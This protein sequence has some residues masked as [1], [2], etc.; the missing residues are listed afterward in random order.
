[1]SEPSLAGLLQEHPYLSL[2]ANNRIRCSLTNHEM[3]PRVDAV[4][5]HING[6][7]FK[8][9]KEWYSYNYDEFL[10]HIVPDRD[11][12]LKLHCKLTG[13]TLNKIP[14]EVRKHVNGKKFLRLVVSNNFI[15][16]LEYVFRS[17]THFLG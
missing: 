4:L 10:P 14:D 13:Q 1:M 6:K 11:N 16:M 9:A 8:K 12:K 7:K 15:D 3:P 5:S 17:C 2:T